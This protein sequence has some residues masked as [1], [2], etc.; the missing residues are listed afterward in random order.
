MKHKVTRLVLAGALLCFAISSHPA[1]IVNSELR[2]NTISEPEIWLT[3]SVSRP[4]DIYSS[5]SAVDSLFR[6]E[7]RLAEDSSVIAQCTDDCIQFSDDSTLSLI[8]RARDRA[9]VKRIFSEK[10]AAYIW[11]SEPVFV[12]FED[13]STMTIE[14]EDIAQISSLSLQL[15]DRDLEM[16]LGAQSRDYRLKEERIDF[17][18]EISNDSSQSEYAL[19]FF[20]RRSLGLWHMWLESSARISNKSENPLNYLEFSI[21][22]SS[23]IVR[24]DILGE[25]F[26]SDFFARSRLF[27]SQSLDTSTIAVEAGVDTTIPNL[28]DLSGSSSRLRLKPLLK[29][30]IGYARHLQSQQLYSHKDDSWHAFLEFYYYVPVGHEFA[31]VIESEATYSESIQLKNNLVSKH[32]VTFA[33]DLPLQDLKAVAKWEKGTAGTSLSHNQQL[34]VGLLVDWA[35]IEN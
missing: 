26:Y 32:A 1:E 7:L 22:S 2:V 33:Y 18:R 3:L 11:I 28:V 12:V 15:S 23:G 19:D 21:I 9:I 24:V 29:L 10:I 34:L 20:T 31:V 17:S 16:L 27:G 6:I 35:G 13:S 5:I 25:D 8:L 4:I 30:G 14:P